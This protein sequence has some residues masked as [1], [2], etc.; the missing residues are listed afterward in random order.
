VHTHLSSFPDELFHAVAMFKWEYT[1]RVLKLGVDVFF[2]EADVFLLRNPLPLVDP[3]LTLQVR[4]C[5]SVCF[6]LLFVRHYSL[7]E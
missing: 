2:A 7:F 1:L 5:F 6:F 3:A 4:F